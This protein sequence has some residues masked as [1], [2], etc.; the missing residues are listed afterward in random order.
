MPIRKPAR[1]V[2]P[3]TGKKAALI[4]TRIVLAKSET[5]V[6][7][8]VI[9]RPTD[10]E[11]AGKAYEIYLASGCQP[12]H[13]L[14]NWLQAE[15]ELLHLPVRHLAAQPLPNPP[16]GKPHHRSIFEMIRTSLL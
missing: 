12:G 16:K 9:K 6:A 3:A 11:I 14:D 8:I 10:A 1:R 13:D 5:R 2:K 7:A 15:Y 4:P